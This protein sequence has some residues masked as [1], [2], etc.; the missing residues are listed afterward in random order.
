M[1]TKLLMLAAVPLIMTTTAGT[2]QQ[3]QSDRPAEGSRI[4]ERIAAR[5]E[6]FVNSITDEFITGHERVDEPLADADSTDVIDTSQ[7]GSKRRLQTLTFDGDKTVEATEDLQ[8]N[9]VV[10]RGNLTVYG[11]IEGDVLVVGGTLYVRDH[12]YVGGNA[13]VVNGDIVKDEDAVVLGYMDKTTSSS[14]S[15][16]E[17]KRTFSR[18]SHRLNANWVK[19]YTNLD[20]FIFRYNRVEGLFLGLGSEKRYYWDGYRSYNSYGSIGYGFKSKGWRGNLGLTRQFAVYDDETGSGHLFEIGVEGYRLTDSKDDW[21]I[22]VHENSAAAIFIHEDFR[23][24][25][26]RRGVAV[27]AGWFTQSED[28]TTQLQLEY[29]SDSYFSMEKR[30]EWSIFGGNKMF[31]ENP[32]IDPG[33]MRSVVGS[34]GLSTLDKTVYGPEGW[35]IYATA[36]VARRGFGS[37]FSF[38]QFVADVRRYQPLGRFDNV[39]V[40]VRLGT[41]GGTVP[42]Q[43]QFDLGGLGTLN[44]FPFKD[45]SGGNRMI[46][47]NFEYIVNGDFLHDLDF[48]PSWILRNFN[49]LLLADAGWIT[50]VPADV[51]W[52]E[53]FESARFS[54]FQSDVGVGFSNRRGSVRAAFV[55]RTDIPSSPRFIFRFSRPF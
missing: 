21:I 15:Y 19:E 36:E 34:G 39:N 26:E 25:Y 13:R 24:Y 45:E 14:S 38:S 49:I 1:R 10:K 8:A 32:P 18:A 33:K 6:Q 51:Q 35:S 30:T 28:L 9:V 5:V 29:R 47:G 52:T 11:K 27:H 37:E 43:K 42:I 17:S 41:S 22:G 55:W 40:R 20:N 7:V 48:W 12:G 23:D 54:G 50:M 31:R 3:E 44:G 4:G 2:A 16:R 53:G 46:L